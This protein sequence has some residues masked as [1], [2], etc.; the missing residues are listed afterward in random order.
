MNIQPFRLEGWKAISSAS[1]VRFLL[2][3]KKKWSVRVRLSV[4]LRL[5]KMKS[6]NTDWEGR[7]SCLSGQNWAFLEESFIG[8]ALE[9][10]KNWNGRSGVCCLPFPGLNY[11]SLLVMG[12]P[13]FVTA[14][15]DIHIEAAHRSAK[16]GRGMF[17]INN[18]GARIY[19]HDCAVS[20]EYLWSWIGPFSVMD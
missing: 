17:L 2:G 6:K 4:Y 11:Q 20:M 16:D 1:Y 14:K 10:K 8:L 9:E 18:N 3:R 19:L 13:G 12:S 7:L 5:E 15:T